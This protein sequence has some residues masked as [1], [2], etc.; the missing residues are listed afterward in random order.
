MYSVA[1]TERNISDINHVFKHES[2]T[3]AN[4]VFST[5][6]AFSLLELRQRALSLLNSIKHKNTLWI[7]AASL[8]IEINSTNVGTAR[9]YRDRHSDDITPSDPHIRLSCLVFL[10]KVEEMGR[11]TAVNW[12]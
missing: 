7:K 3:A 10:E 6:V 4:F 8:N 12:I 11:N 9:K 1:L 2:A 5:S